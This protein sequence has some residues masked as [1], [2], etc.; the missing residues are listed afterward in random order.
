MYISHIYLKIYF[1]S[2]YLD[3]Q[4]KKMDFVNKFSL[5]VWNYM[6]IKYLFSESSVLLE[7][8]IINILKDH[9]FFFFLKDIFYFILF[10]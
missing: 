7:K 6:A 2:P 9:Q 8:K 4:E 5:M 1:F 10:H 3:Y